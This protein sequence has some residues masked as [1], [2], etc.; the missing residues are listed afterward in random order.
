[1]LPAGGAYAVV[2][3][4][5]EKGYKQFFASNRLQPYHNRFKI[6]TFRSTVWRIPKNEI[7][8][9]PSVVCHRKYRH[10]HRSTLSSS[11]A[12]CP[13]D[14]CHPVLTSN[15][16]SEIRLWRPINV[17]P[18]KVEKFNQYSIGKFQI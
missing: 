6:C 1:M 12:D 11:F 16:W 9:P 3:R 17:L 15:R 7:F 8:K 2:V 4:S 5:Q 18:V 13:E 10:Y 14:V